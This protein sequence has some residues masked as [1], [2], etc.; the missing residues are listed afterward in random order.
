LSEVGRFPLHFDIVKSLINYWYRLENINEFPLLQEAYQC[1]KNLHADHHN[2]WYATTD[3]IL[4]LF[5]ID[6]KCKFLTSCRFK[7]MSKIKIKSK[8]LEDWKN[9]RTSYQD[10]KLHSYCFFKDIF[11]PEKYLQIVNNRDHRRAIS[12]FRISAHK[13]EIELGRY[14]RPKTPRELRYCRRC[15][16]NSIDDELHFLLSCSSLNSAR[17]SLTDT[18]S[19][20]NK[21]FNNISA[22]DKFY[23]I[24]NCE[25]PDILREVGRYLCGNL[26]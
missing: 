23:W 22:K 4:K 9:S 5:N 21:N 20:N 15:G 26:P 3:K 19:L 12:R 8:Y 10:G 17:E 2:S 13:L 18:I 24:M 11:S 16:T 7:T 6:D 25:D 14:N 1:S